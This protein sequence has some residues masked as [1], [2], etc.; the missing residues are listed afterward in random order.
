MKTR[1]TSL[2]LAL[3]LLLCA[4]A[5]IAEETKDAIDFETDLFLVPINY[6]GEAPGALDAPDTALHYFPL[7]AEM[8]MNG[9]WLWGAADM[10]EGYA[11]ATEGRNETMHVWCLK[12]PDGTQYIPLFV[13]FESL[14]HFYGRNVHVAV[15]S[16]SEAAAMTGTPITDMVDGE[17]VELPCAGIVVAPGILDRIIPTADLQYMYG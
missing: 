13:S 15:I 8:T 4:P 17:A 10:P 9:A 1:I 12:A 5:C 6:T 16:F 3:I 2:V 7:A 11:P 14:F